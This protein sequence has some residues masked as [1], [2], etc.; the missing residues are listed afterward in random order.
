MGLMTLD[1]LDVAWKE[2]RTPPYESE[3]VREALKHT[4]TLEYVDMTDIAPDVKPTLH[5]T[6]HILGSAVSHFHIGEGLYNVAFSGDIH[7]EDI[8]LF[9]GAV[10]EFPRVETLVM[11]STYGG[12]NGYQIDHA[13]A[14]PGRPGRY[15][16][17]ARQLFGAR[18]RRPLR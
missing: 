8:R 15:R 1:Y 3:M 14:Q 13:A 6:G 9:N 18:H 12:R 17:K 7:Y 11:E 16:L 2:G 10:N 4:I 5:N